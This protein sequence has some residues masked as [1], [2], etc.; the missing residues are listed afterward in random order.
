MSRHLD[1]VAIEPSP[2]SS[3]VYI[4]NSSNDLLPPLVPSRCAF[5]LFDWLIGEELRRSQRVS[6]QN[7]GISRFWGNFWFRSNF[8]IFFS[9][10]RC[11]PGT[12]LSKTEFLAVVSKMAKLP[13]NVIFDICWILPI[14]GTV[15]S[16]FSM[17]NRLL[18]NFPYWNPDFE[19]TPGEKLAEWYSSHI[20]GTEAFFNSGYQYSRRVCF[21][22]DACRNPD[23]VKIYR[24]F[25]S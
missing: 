21:S 24:K 7:N 5:I 16:S 20:P 9:Y 19:M 10:L 4:Y 14:F 12:H 8:F 6:H 25:F 18:A 17:E 22:F 11:W 23:W 3:C 13:Q 1:W 2:L 15:T